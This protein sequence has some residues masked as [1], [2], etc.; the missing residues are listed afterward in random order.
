MYNF[1]CTHLHMHVQVQKQLK[2]NNASHTIMMNTNSLITFAVWKVCLFLYEKR[3][4]KLSGKASS[5][6][7]PNNFYHA[8]TFTW[9]GIEKCQVILQRV[10]FSKPRSTAVYRATTARA[11]TIWREHQ[12]PKYPPP[13]RRNSPSANPGNQ[14]YVAKRRH[15][16]LTKIKRFPG[17]SKISLQTAITAYRYTLVPAGGPMPA[18]LGPHPNS[19]KRDGG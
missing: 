8:G 15:P 16:I 4:T 5:S 17:M 10:R 12:P 13:P 3:K 6:F 1:V 9:R 14:S 18:L 11:P 2:A 19:E 7:T